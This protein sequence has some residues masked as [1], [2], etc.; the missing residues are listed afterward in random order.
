MNAQFI[1]LGTPSD[2]QQLIASH[3]GLSGELV[4]LGVAIN[5]TFPAADSTGQ[6]LDL[7]EQAAQTHDLIFLFT[8]GD[9]KSVV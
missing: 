9:R 6:L 3:Q 7:L 8:Q 4:H 5:N 1:S 2:V